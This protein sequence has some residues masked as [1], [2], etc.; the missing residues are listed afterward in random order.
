MIPNIYCKCAVFLKKWQTYPGGNGSSSLF[1]LVLGPVGGGGL[2][3][4]AK[5]RQYKRRTYI[6]LVKD[7]TEWL[8]LNDINPFSTNVPQVDLHLY[9]KCH[10]STGVFETIC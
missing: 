1:E 4:G 2:S 3:G 7:K 6:I 5:E 8:H 10:S 9:L